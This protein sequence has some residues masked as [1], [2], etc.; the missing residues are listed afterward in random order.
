MYNYLLQI[1]S[2][3]HIDYE[4]KEREKYPK[5][6]NKRKGYHYKSDGE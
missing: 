4:K 6:S 1:I 5:L 2:L 3:E